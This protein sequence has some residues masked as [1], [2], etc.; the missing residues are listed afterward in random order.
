MYEVR[1][2]GVRCVGGEVC[3]RLGMYEVRCAGGVV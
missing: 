2:A 1:C 3:M